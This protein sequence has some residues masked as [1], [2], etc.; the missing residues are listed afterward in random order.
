MLL[1]TAYTAGLSYDVDANFFEIGICNIL[2]PKFRATV[3]KI[4]GCFRRE[5]HA[6][7]PQ[8]MPINCLRDY[9]GVYVTRTDLF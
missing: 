6:V 2:S 1:Y 5:K 4:I 3:R 9:P 7:V 8:A